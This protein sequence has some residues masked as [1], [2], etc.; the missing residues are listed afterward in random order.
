MFLRLLLSETY[1]VPGVDAE[2]AEQCFVAV[3]APPLVS[4]AQ[5]LVDVLKL[6]PHGATHRPAPTNETQQSHRLTGFNETLTQTFTK[7][8]NSSDG[9]FNYMHFKSNLKRSGSS[10]QHLL[11]QTTFC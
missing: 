10:L 6:R 1:D 3:G 4:E 8:F 11:L 7:Q 2:A 9:S 5:R